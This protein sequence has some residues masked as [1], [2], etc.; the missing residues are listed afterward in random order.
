MFDAIAMSTW[1]KHSNLKKGD[2][3]RTVPVRGIRT[4]GIRLAATGHEPFAG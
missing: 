3:D 2:M 4:T 1:I